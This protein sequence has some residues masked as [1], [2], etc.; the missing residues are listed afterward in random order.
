[1][2]LFPLILLILLSVQLSNAQG[3]P[4]N[5]ELVKTFHLIATAL[6]S[7]DE[8]LLVIYDT[9]N[10]EIYAVDSLKNKNIKRLYRIKV[11]QRVRIEN[12]FFLDKNSK[13]YCP[14]GPLLN[15]RFIELN[16]ETGKRKKLKCKEMTQSCLYKANKF[17]DWEKPLLSLN[18]KPFFLKYNNHQMSLSIYRI[19]VRT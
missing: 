6:V 2:K 19:G 10:I 16:L 18:K 13:F 15:P 12:S 7:E 17:C 11:G 3:E 9:R 14:Y 8:S 5:K 4:K 1:M